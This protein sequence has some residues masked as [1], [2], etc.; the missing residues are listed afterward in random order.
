LADLIQFQFKE[1][2]DAVIDI[3]SKKKLITV[4]NIWELFAIGKKYSCENLLNICYAFIDANAAEILKQEHT[5][6]IPLPYVKDIFGR[7]TLTAPESDIY[8]FVNKWVAKRPRE[9]HT[10]LLSYIFQRLEAMT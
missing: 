7:N 10:R 2:A 9:D 1:Q 3:T 5:L 4:K 8:Q 6:T